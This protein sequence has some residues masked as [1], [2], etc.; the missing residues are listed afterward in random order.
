[1]DKFAIGHRGRSHEAGKMRNLLRSTLAFKWQITARLNPALIRSAPGPY[2]FYHG[3]SNLQNQVG[4]TFKP[5]SHDLLFIN[6][7]HIKPV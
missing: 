5:G 3:E 7:L 4:L 6:S 2:T 1:M